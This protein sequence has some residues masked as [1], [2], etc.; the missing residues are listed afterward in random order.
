MKSEEIAKAKAAADEMLQRLYDAIDNLAEDI[1]P[2]YDRIEDYFFQEPWNQIMSNAC[3]I[4]V[5][6]RLNLPSM[7]LSKK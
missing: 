6:S 7:H 1:V 2:L 5:M 3:L 4:C